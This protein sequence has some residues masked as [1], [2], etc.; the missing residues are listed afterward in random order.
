MG[1]KT[2]SHRPRGIVTRDLSRWCLFFPGTAVPPSSLR[3]LS[4][5]LSLCRSLLSRVCDLFLFVCIYAPVDVLF[6]I[7]FSF[8]KQMSVF[9]GHPRQWQRNNG[10][11]IRGIRHCVRACALQLL[12]SFLSSFYL[13]LDLYFFAT[14]RKS[15]TQGISGIRSDSISKRTISR[16]CINTSLFSLSLRMIER[17]YDLRINIVAKKNVN[18]RFFCFLERR[19]LFRYFIE[20][21]LPSLGYWPIFGEAILSHFE[22]KFVY[23]ASLGK[24]AF[25]LNCP[26]SLLFVDRKGIESLALSVFPP[27]GVVS[28]P[29]SPLV[30]SFC[31]GIKRFRW[32]CR[33]VVS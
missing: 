25:F 13:S 29:E 16:S 3:C 33:R 21:V 27:L 12:S 8:F 24:Q 20:F 18:K 10:Y 6:S 31:A 22:E 26:F 11:L 17:F 30:L 19:E 7:F 2:S 15:A 23:R 5:C 28:L 4:D 1:G 32:V 14:D 9:S